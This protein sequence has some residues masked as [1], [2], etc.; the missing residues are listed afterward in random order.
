MAGFEPGTLRLQDESFTTKP[1]LHIAVI[2]P[3]DKT[4]DIY[5]VFENVLRLTKHK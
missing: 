5:I 2:R 4:C 1:Q 3:L